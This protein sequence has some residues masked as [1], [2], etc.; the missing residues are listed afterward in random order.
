MKRA[1]VLG[2]GG[3]EGAFQAGAIAELLERGFVPDFICGVSAGALNG[4]FIAERSG[5]VAPGTP[6]DWQAIGK[7]LA[8]FWST[9]ITAPSSIMRKRSMIEL[10]WMIVRSR[11]DGMVDNTP[12]RKL[13]KQEI[14]A[15]YLSNAVPEFSAAAVNL[16]TGTLDY[17]GRADVDLIDF[18]MA[19]AAVPIVSPI[20]RIGGQPYYD[21]GIREMAPLGKAKESGADCIVCVLCQAQKVGV[22]GFNE[23]NLMQLFGRVVDIVTNAIV[24]DDI[25]NTRAINDLYS[26]LGTKSLATLATRFRKV[27][28]VQPIRPADPLTVPLES[29]TSADIA[30]LIELGRAAVRPLSFPLC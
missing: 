18:V 9:R 21:G 27:K 30:K 19:S 29:F 15:Q 20:A 3:I 5:R 1:L 24:E 17:R 28:L 11:F 13:M 2:G 4:A 22:G 14:L 25:E 23:G 26:A 7:D 8:D 10:L 16:E 12:F 6:V